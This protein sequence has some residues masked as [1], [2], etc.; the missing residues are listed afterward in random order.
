MMS[1][2]QFLF[3]TAMFGVR[4]RGRFNADDSPE[5]ES[6]MGVPVF[7]LFVSRIGPPLMTTPGGWRVA[8]CQNGAHR[9]SADRACAGGA[10]ERR[11]ASARE[12]SGEHSARR[13]PAQ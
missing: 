7:Y 9:L 4:F 3:P 6:Q 8:R 11:D 1:P 12:E 13:F 2:E 5:A 10:V